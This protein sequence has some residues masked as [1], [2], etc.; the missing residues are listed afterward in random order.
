MIIS[1]WNVRG[2]NDPIKQL[3]VRS[4]LYQNKIEVL[5][6]LETRVRLNNSA[7]ISKKF[8]TYTIINNYSHHCNG[9][10]WVFLDIRRVTVVSAQVHDQ[11]IHLELLNNRTNK[12]VFLTF[13]YASNDAGHRERL[14]DEL[15]RLNGK[16]T[17][18][19]VLGDFNIVKD[20][21]ERLGPNPL[22]VNEMMAFNQCL[23]DCTLDDLHSFGCEHTWTNK[24]EATARVWSRLD[25]V[26]SN[27]S[28]LLE[29]PNTQVHVLP[30][31]ISDHSPLLVTVQDNYR[32]RKQFSYLNCWADHKEYDEMVMQAWGLPVRGSVMFKFFGKLKHVRKTLIKLHNTSYSRI[33]KRVQE[34][35][36]ALE[37]C[38]NQLQMRPLDP[39]LFE[40]EQQL[41]NQYLIF[42]K[43]EKSSLAQR[44]KIQDVKYNDAPTNYY[45]SKIAARKHQVTIGR[46]M[47]RQGIEKIGSQ[48][49]NQAFVDYY[50]WLL[51]QNVVVNCESM[52]ELQGNKILTSDWEGLCREIT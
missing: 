37:T 43:T 33:S 2:F 39:T 14:W 28:W 52:T 25:R 3:E 20:M 22:S 41:L 5:G 46:I 51:G 27:P 47:D 7:A 32:P 48:D 6:L 23:L 24:R 35:K 15:R 16:V 17:N 42:K 49:V 36:T 10:I 26:L 21:D 30:S 38:Q 34:A 12:I 50:R 13:V 40:Q 9:R 8:S 11:F 18:W 44:A 19:I 45:F 29:Y 1:S 4:Y 31:G